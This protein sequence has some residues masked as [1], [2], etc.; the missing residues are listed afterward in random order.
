MPHAQACRSLGVRV[1]RAEML[2]DSTHGWHE[3]TADPWPWLGYFTSV[4]AGA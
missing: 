1:T 4:I 2:L 3:G